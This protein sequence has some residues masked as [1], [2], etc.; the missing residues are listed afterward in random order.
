[1]TIKDMPHETVEQVLELRKAA[2]ELEDRAYELRAENTTLLNTINILIRYS[3]QA[4][5]AFLYDDADRLTE[6]FDSLPI[7]IQDKICEYCKDIN[8]NAQS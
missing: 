7:E 4:D 3:A 1:M 5:L 6:L 2:I 8:K